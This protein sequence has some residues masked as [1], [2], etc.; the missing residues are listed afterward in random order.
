MLAIED[1]SLSTNDVVLETQVDVHSIKN[2]TQE[3]QRS[4]ESTKTGIR[5]FKFL[6]SM[7]YM[8]LRPASGCDS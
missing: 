1:L 8:N 2:T 3:V 4:V 5:S 6:C 7:A